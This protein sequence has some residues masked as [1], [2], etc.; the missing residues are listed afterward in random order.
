M[1]R[2]TGIIVQARMGSSRLEGKV[3]KTVGGKPLLEYELERLRRAKLA[4]S[5]RVATTT[6]ARDEA[7]VLFCARLGVPVFRG[8]E[9]DVLSRYYHAAK[10]AE[11]H[12]VVRVTADCPLIDPAVIDSVIAYFYKDGTF[13]YVSNTLTRSFPRGMDTEVFTFK[14]LEKS[15]HEADAQPD[16]EHVTPYI[17]RHPEIFRI[18]EVLSGRDLGGHRWTVDTDD[19][20]K[21]IHH[22]LEALYPS[23]PAFSMDDALELLERHPEWRVLN[24]HVRQKAYGEN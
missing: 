12:T 10:E 9:E 15:H 19:D 13:D 14:A 17:Y 8:S 20:F 2:K 23:R 18:G 16:R 1:N 3:L 5:V 22:M 6:H 24:A 21:L 7:I 4:D 11:L